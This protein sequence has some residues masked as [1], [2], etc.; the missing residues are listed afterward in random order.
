MAIFLPNQFRWLCRSAKLDILPGEEPIPLFC[1]LEKCDKP[2]IQVAISE[3]G[4][5]VRLSGRVDIDSS[6]VLL[7]RFLALFEAPHATV[8]SIDF[9]RVSHLDSS[10]IATLIEALRIA[11]SYN[12]E[13][14]LQGLAGRLLQLFQST[15]ILS[16]F[17]G[18]IVTNLQC[19]SR[20][21]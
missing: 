14:R 15:G 5:L 20:A 4:V 2:E 9:S 17:N 13:L 21:V 11:R 6:P 8:V 16:L 3:D 12:T 7:K 10:G 19:G 1:E 18:S